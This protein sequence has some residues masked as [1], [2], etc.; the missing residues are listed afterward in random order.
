MKIYCARREE[1]DETLLD[2]MIGEDLWIKVKIPSFLYAEYMV[3]VKA[4]L[5]DNAYLI[6]QISVDYI[7]IV[8]GTVHCDSSLLDMLDND[9]VKI[10]L[11]NIQVVKP[12]EI[13][14][15]EELFSCRRTY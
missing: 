11:D 1:T 7:H 12:V 8:D 15:T 14:S 5:P 2:R 9:G 3:R 6:N 4:K 13:F 10:Y